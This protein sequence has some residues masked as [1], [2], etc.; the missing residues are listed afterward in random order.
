M[1]IREGFVSNSSSSSFVITLNKSIEDIPF[2]DFEQ[3]FDLAPFYEYFNVDWEVG[4]QQL[5]QALCEADKLDTFVYV[6]ELGDL[7]GYEHVE[8]AYA[9]IEELG[10]TYLEAQKQQLQERLGLTW[11]EE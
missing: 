1:K 5:Y 7:A 8:H 6:V 2:S 9:L 4:I 3:A 10:F 11:R